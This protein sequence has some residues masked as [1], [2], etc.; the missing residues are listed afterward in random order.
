MTTPNIPNGSNLYGTLGPVPSNTLNAAIRATRAPGT[1]D[2]KGPNGNF[3]IGQKWVNTS[4]NSTYTLTNLTV[5]NGL[6][7]ATWTQEGGS[8]SG[9]IESIAGNS[10]T[11]TPVAG[12][13][14]IAGATNTVV[15]TNSGSTSTVT[16]AAQLQ[17]DSISAL[18]PSQRTTLG[19]GTATTGTGVTAI[20]YNALNS[21]STNNVTAVGVEALGSLTS[22]TASTAVGVNA[23]ASLSSN[24]NCT[25]VG[26]SALQN[27]TAAESTAVGASC[28]AANVGG[29]GNTGVGYECLS[30]NTSGTSLTGIGNGAL[31]STVSANNSTAVGYIALN[32]S[33]GDRNTAVGSSVLSQCTSGVRNSCLGSFSGTLVTSGQGNTFI[34]ESAGDRITSGSFNICLGDQCGLG[35]GGTESNNILIGASVPGNT[36]VSNTIVIGDATYSTNF[37]GGIRD[38]V[39]AQNDAI[40][41]LIDSLGQLGTTSSS[42]RY[43][44]NIKDLSGSERIYDLRAVSFKYK[45]QESDRPH[46]GLIAEEVFETI[47]EIVVRGK[48]GTIE[49]IQYQTLPIFLLAE[50][51]KLRKEI[52]ELKRGK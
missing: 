31:K 34:G 14:T 17:G 1:T 26:D 7:S 38:I 45:S 8:G 3:P 48:D 28:L 49:T 41:V 42:I 25:A 10:G 51:Q 16:F 19:V 11:I 36:G 47:P 6:V 13:V 18:Q 44:E 4:A 33:E 40:P 22:G 21:A 29:T 5:S 32:L 37:Q 52:D 15:F 12:A 39:T 30:L 2:I 20:G 27:N 23:L 9:G 24:D 46:Y 50:I 43:K 35:L